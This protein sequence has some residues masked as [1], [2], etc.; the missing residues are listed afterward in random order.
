MAAT[1]VMAAAVD[2]PTKRSNL[3]LEPKAFRI[4][5]HMR[6][7]ICFEIELLYIS[8]DRIDRIQTQVGLGGEKESNVYKNRA[9]FVSEHERGSRGAGPLG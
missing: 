9:A 8:S 6:A 3:T 2:P 1:L 4:P 7:R 5:D